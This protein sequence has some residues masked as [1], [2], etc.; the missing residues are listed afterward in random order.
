MATIHEN[1]VLIS[2]QEQ[3]S[4]AT[5]WV[6]VVIEAH[7]SKWIELD[8]QDSRLQKFLTNGFGMIDEI[9]RCR[10]EVSLKLMVAKDNEDN[11]DPAGEGGDSEG[12][13][14]KRAKKH[15]ADEIEGHEPSSQCHVSNSSS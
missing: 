2:D 8:R 11:V 6:V 7:D 13:A 1:I 4:L 3:P 5:S 10:N 14:L 15:A 9:K 12:P